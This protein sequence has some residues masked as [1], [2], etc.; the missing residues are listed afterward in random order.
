[1]Y[2]ICTKC[3]RVF[4][5]ESTLSHVNKCR[6]TTFACSECDEELRLQDIPEHLNC[7]RAIKTVA[8]ALYNPKAVLRFLYYFHNIEN[9]ECRGRY[10]T[11]Y[12]SNGI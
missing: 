2:Y 4:R 11:Y 10:V 3:H 1:M 5:K 7:E 12:R 6:G 9:T 8:P